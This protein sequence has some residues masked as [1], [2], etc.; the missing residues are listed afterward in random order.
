MSN[1]PEPLTRRRF[2]QAGLAAAGLWA[3]PAGRA[4]SRGPDP[5]KVGVILPYSGVYASQGEEITRGMV[6]YFEQTGYQAAGR[7]VHLIY[8]DETQHPATAMRKARKL[9]EADR[10]HLLTGLVSSPSVLAVRDYIHEARI[11]LVVGNASANAV[12]REWKSPY[13]FRTSYSSWQLSYPFGPWVARHIARRVVMVTSDYTPG[14]ESGDGFKESFLASGGE[15]VDEILTPLGSTDFSPYMGRIARARPEALFTFLAGSDGAIFLRQFAQFGLSRRIPLAVSGAMVQEE[16]LRAVGEEAE[17]AYSI[18]NWATTLALPANKA[19]VEAYERRF[20]LDP[21][22]PSVLGFD[23]ARFIVEGLEAVQGEPGDKQRLVEAFEAVEFDSPRGY[24]E[25]DPKTH[26]VVQN[27]YV[28]QVRRSNGH[29]INALV[30][31]L[32]RFADPA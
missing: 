9:V 13:I 11:P 7:P 15:V 4:F 12:T 20:H 5:I 17:G 16:I 27:V 26:N 25:M 31:D 23:A 28:R 10:V 29:F 22:T 6:L 18:H 24:F 8:E 2:L 32:G 1:V 30:E 3:V 21:S 14:W 19:F